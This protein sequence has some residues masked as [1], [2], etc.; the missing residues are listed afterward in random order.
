MKRL[1]LI[2]GILCGSCWGQVPWAG[3]LSPT[4]AVDWRNAGFTVPNITTVCTTLTSAAT[5]AQINTAI[6]NCSTAGGGVVNLAA[7]TIGSPV[8]YSLAG[9]VDLKSNVV[10]RGG[11]PEVTTLAFTSQ[12][13]SCN[14][15]LTYL[16]GI[17]G[18]NNY[19]NGGEQNLVNWTGGYTQGGTTITVS[20]AAGIVAN[21]TVLIL[22]QAN[23]A[24]DT[25]NY[26]V[27]DTTSCSTEGGSPGGNVGG[28]D[29]N[30]Q[31]Y[32]LV[33]N[34][35]GTTLTT[36]P[37]LYSPNWRSS[38]TPRAWHATTLITHAGIEN[39]TIDAT[40]SGLSNGSNV[41]F[42]NSYQCW[43]K[44]IRSI[45]NLGSGTGGRNH[46]W[47]QYSE[48]DVQRD[49]YFYGTKNATNLSYGIE[50][51]Q[52]GDNLAENNIFQ[53][54]VSPYLVGNCEGCVFSYSFGVNNYNNPGADFNEP[55]PGFYHDAGTAYDLFES[56][57]GTGEVFDNI[58]GTHNMLTDFR[59]QYFARDDATKAFQLQT[60]EDAS[61]ARYIAI[62]GGVLGQAGLTNQYQS[63]AP[64][65]TNCDTAVFTFGWQIWGPSCT[66]SLD[67]TLTLGTSMRWANWD[68]VT[69][70]T[71]YCSPAD[72]GFASA[73][74]SSTSE[75]PTGISPYAAIDPYPN[76]G[77]TLPA[78][79][80]LSGQPSWWQFPGVGSPSPFP[81]I[82][83]DVTGG[84]VTSGTGTGSTLG[85]HVYN[86]P[87]RSCFL[88]VMGGTPAGTGGVLPFD[89]N[90]CYVAPV[91]TGCGIPGVSSNQR[92]FNITTGNV[93][94]ASP[95]PSWGPNPTP[96]GASA[97]NPYAV[98]LTGNLV[99]SGTAVVPNDTLGRTVVRCSDSTF[100]SGQLWGLADNG[101]PNLFA[102]DTSALIFK[103]NGGTRYIVAVNP[104]TGQCVPITGISVP[105][106]N[107][108]FSHTSPT[109]L[110][111]LGGS[112]TSQISSIP[113]TFTCSPFP[114]V[115]GSA[116]SGSLG[117]PT[118]LYDF[119]N[120]GCI[121]N[122]YN[123]N[124]SW[125]LG[126]GSVGSFTDSRDDTQFSIYYSDHNVP[127][128][129]GRWV[130]SWN[131]SW[132][133]SSGCYIWDTESGL[134]LDHLGN[135]LGLVNILPPSQALDRFNI[136][137]GFSILESA[138]GATYIAVSTGQ[139]SSMLQGSYYNG[140]YAALVDSASVIHAGYPVPAPTGGV[141][142]VGSLTSGTFT[143][144]ETVTQAVTGATGT[145]VK[146][147]GG[148]PGFT[149]GGV[150]LQLGTLSGGTADC[151]SHAWV[152]NTSLAVYT[153]TALP[154]VNPPNYNFA[155]HWADGFGSA[156]AGKQGTMG[157]YSNPSVPGTSTTPNGAPCSDSHFSWNFD[158][159]GDLYPSITTGQDYYINF[160][161]LLQLQSLSTFPA[162]CPYYN[163]IVA[164]NIGS[165][166]GINPLRLAHT[167]NSGWYWTFDGNDGVVCVEASQGTW[168]AF[169]TDGYGQ[170]GSI[171]GSP[172]CNVGG[173]DW[174]KSD[175]TDF[176][177]SGAFGSIIMPQNGGNASNYVYV[178]NN[179]T[180]NGGSG[181]SCTTGATEPSFGTCTTLGCTLNEATPGTI[182][183][184]LA[185]DSQ[186]NTIPAVQNC[187]LEVML[188]KMF[189]G[190]PTVQVPPAPT[191]VIFAGVGPLLQFASGGN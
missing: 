4:R 186:T 134:A 169:I 167:Y 30:Q 177:S 34:V 64:S 83:P 132:G 94:L 136:H 66:T 79:F 61:Y 28:I 22:D 80:Y 139:Q 141:S 150:V 43:M 100:F 29:Y 126:S 164:S 178:V 65:T 97:G 135:H 12:G 68:V 67:A 52:A 109:T 88:N 32:K 99:G 82:G 44:N 53:Q 119:A 18:S 160:V 14:G 98:Q 39:L 51:W 35:S 91:A 55:G 15:P 6:A 89:A 175:T 25:G 93:A 5:L 115:S 2:F 50:S 72:P 137:E 171:S 58:H 37:P 90:S 190:A 60:V 140:F 31:E 70:G 151:C 187:R 120:S 102:S 172:H 157:L 148:T 117:S 33:T 133:P 86:I 152:G 42:W 161:G 130:V 121:Q 16:I 54:I 181:A 191:V 183:W 26:Y 27:C 165:S 155:G 101:E 77:H 105:N 189:E 95:I 85:G 84:N 110:Y 128:Q 73:P 122:P 57:Q 106:G 159:R 81:A 124:P 8:V 104:A 48:Q 176:N 188:V 154:A 142:I 125:T 149:V 92:C 146:P 74:C 103:A 40:N 20:S 62:I 47:I 111:S 13:D 184:T 76:V 96:T 45:Y 19:S 41:L 162:G 59:P 174:Q 118:L 116:C 170:F 129:H 69:N 166:V 153:P 36:F 38:P 182:Q 23:D 114:L 1:L 156:V 49:S 46:V 173:P 158:V 21:Q 179:C 63:V 75:V 123:G 143:L 163:E 71:R 10:L 3:L 127:A 138:P 180:Q 145:I 87:A 11:G 147:T 7:G 112:N 108:I 131:T 168:C 78:S 17:C 107:L 113:L 56:N 24:T 144:G 185:R 9:E